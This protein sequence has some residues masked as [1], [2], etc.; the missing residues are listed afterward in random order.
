MRVRNKKIISAS[1][2]TDI[3]AFYSD[4][5]MNR[6]REGFCYAPNPLYAKQIT[7][8]VSLAPE[9]V[10]IIV[11]WTRDA[12]PL[13]KYLPEL[14][15]MGY[16]YYLQYTV[17]GYPKQID[18]YSPSLNCAI[19]TFKE[20]SSRIGKE[21]VIWR[22]DPVLLSDITDYKWH[23]ENLSYILRNIKGYTESLII[24]FIDPYRKNSLRLAPKKDN[25]FNLYP[26]AF[27]ASA[28]IEL[29][30]WIGAKMGKAKLNIT[31]CAEKIDLSEFGIEHG[32]C[33]DDALINKITGNKFV[34][35]KDP[36]QREECGCVI[37][38][39]I[40][41]NDTCVF[42]CK[43]C[44]AT[45]NFKRA[46]DNFEKHDPNHYSLASWFQAG[47]FNNSGS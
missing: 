4:W 37:S 22:Y 32:K 19:K 16:K 12:K 7:K 35:R 20:L 18:P 29:S 23:K 11:F 41:V 30:K 44:Y 24:S 43:Y 14:D 9:D 38:K 46:K 40:G 5:F 34:S 1:R 45:N 27:D 17:L 3:P 8:M 47:N 31:T 33:I 13:I 39:D 15:K 2:R 36:A 6:I 26:D 42:G 21:K 28:Y 25:N 10:E